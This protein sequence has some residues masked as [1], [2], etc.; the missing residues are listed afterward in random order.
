MA[1]FIFAGLDHPHSWDSTDRMVDFFDLK[2]VLENL[3]KGIGVDRVSFEKLSLPFYH[4]G[5]QAK[6]VCNG[7][8]IGSIGEVHPELQM[9]LDI[10]ERVIVAEI[11]LQDLLAQKG[12][13]KKM[14]P[15]PLYPSSSRDWTVTV[16]EEVPVSR[17]FD[18][19]HSI[20]SRYLEAVKLKY[21]YRSDKLGEKKKNVTM[22][23]IYRDLDETIENKTVD[24]EH[25]RIVEQ[26]TEAI[27]MS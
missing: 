21:I 23:F 6:I 18:A 7:L 4:P 19:I 2:G 8:E 3:F 22:H 11:S 24:L 26:A 17:I 15:L 9:K 20:D 10:P 1:T 5:R 25:A 27:K 16:K 12:L 13:P 14:E